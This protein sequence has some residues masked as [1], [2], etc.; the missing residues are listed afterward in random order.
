MIYRHWARW[1]PIHHLIALYF[2]AGKG[3]GVTG[4]RARL[5]RGKEAEELNKQGAEALMQFM[6]QTR[7]MIH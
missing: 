7:H 3:G 1:P 6:D 4:R 2:G 5:L